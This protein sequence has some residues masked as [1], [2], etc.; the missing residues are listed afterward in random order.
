MKTFLFRVGALMLLLFL[1][2][3]CS[4]TKSTQS[5]VQLGKAGFA[6]DEEIYIPHLKSERK[7]FFPETL[8][9]THW[10]DSIYNQM[11]FEEKVGQLFMVA[12][13]SNKDTIHTNAIEKLIKDYKIGGLIFFQGG[14]GR[15][16]RLTNKYQS[17]SK[18]PLF[19]GIDI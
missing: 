4:S 19:I 1:V 6:E 14:P 12:A 9:E 11:T 5:N 3:N 8:A 2:A 15:Q 7:N 18:V 13:Y 10:V 17:L 16:A